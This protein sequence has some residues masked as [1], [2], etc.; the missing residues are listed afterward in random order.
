MENST[1]PSLDETKVTIL[2]NFSKKR[3]WS[4]RESG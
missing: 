2:K 3:K 4:F 1:G